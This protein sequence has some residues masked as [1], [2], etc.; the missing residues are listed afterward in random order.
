MYA[1]SSGTTG[2]AK[3]IPVTPESLAQSRAAQRALAYVQ[4]RAVKALAGKVLGIAGSARE[5]TL[6]HGVAAGATTGLIYATMPRAMRTKYVLTPEVFAIEDYEERYRAIARLAALEP[7]ITMIATAN[8]S[9]ILRLLDV[10]RGDLPEIAEA[11][12][13]PRRSELRRL[14]ARAERVTIAELWPNLRSVL[15]WIGG[16]C[17]IAG[18]KVRA[19]LPPDCR[20][21]DAG[22]VASEVRGTIV[23]DIEN[24]LAL[25]MLQ[26]VFFEFAEVNA[27]DVG[28]RD[29][30][31]LHELEE[32][33]EYYV[34][35]TTIA[36]LLRY[37]MNDVLRCAKAAASPTSPA[38]SCRR[39]NCM[40]RWA[41]SRPRRTSS[42]RSPTRQRR[43][44]ASMLRLETPRSSQRRRSIR[45]CASSIWNMT[46][47]VGAGVC[48]RPK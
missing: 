31:L 19:E 36:G 8:P 47:S 5:E 13:E 15:T 18:E 26:D 14:A 30:L 6:A 22:Y 11:A 44:I 28:K 37:H 43:A 7:D 25:P 48:L 35:V 10:L 42:S 24:N 21:V 16:G 2:A 46:P 4:H 20:M 41:C 29:T 23:V 32:G 3:Y 34:F 17:A 12:C 38:R 9:T 40:P 27:W 1:R 39:I 45:A 33:G